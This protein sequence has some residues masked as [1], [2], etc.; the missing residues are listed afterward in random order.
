MPAHRT[1]PIR[2]DIV[3]DDES[4]P[5]RRGR[6]EA[7]SED[8]PAADDMDWASVRAE[9]SARVEKELEKLRAEGAP[10]RAE[11]PSHA[12]NLSS[13]FWG[14]AWN[15]NLMAY[16][17]YESRMPRGRTYFRSGKVLDLE[18]S[19]GNIS[20]LV[21]GT[22]VYS[23]SIR[24]APLEPEKWDKLKVRCMGKIGGLMELLSGSLS[25]EVMKEV[26]D[27]TQGLFPSPAEMKLSCTCPDYAGL[28]KHLAA[29]L[30]ATGSRFDTQPQALFSLRGVDPREMVE[31]NTAEAVARLTAPADAAGPERSA[32]LNGVDLGALFGL[33]ENG[34]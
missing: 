16:S 29:V 33:A 3:Y 17:D 19:G 8:M 23:V 26:T 18:I 30:Y 11:A 31:V 7:D 13:T 21:A 14:Q 5:R 10:L 9:S 6:R 34:E 12:R 32:A 4:P 2:D 28:C 15:R 1:N 22:R 20:A 25:D 24:V 27:L